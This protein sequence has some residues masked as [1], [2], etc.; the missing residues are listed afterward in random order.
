MGINGEDIKNKLYLRL[1]M[2]GLADTTT[3]KLLNMY[4]DTVSMQI[5][6]E[7]WYHDLLKTEYLDTDSDGKFTIEQN[8]VPYAV[9]AY[10]TEGERHTWQRLTPIDYEYFLNWDSRVYRG[11][12]SMGGGG[13]WSGIRRRYTVLPEGDSDHTV[14][15]ILEI[16]D[17]VPIKIVYY[18]IRPA[19]S[20][21]SIYFEP[22]ITGKVLEAYYT[23]KGDQLKDRSIKMIMDQ[24]EKL[25]KNIRKQAETFEVNALEKTARN[26]KTKDWLNAENDIGYWM[27]Y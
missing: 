25:S 3:D 22:L 16:Q 15:Q 10:G 18:P 1:N 24:N 23:D 14:M 6:A 27:S 21:F 8:I 4:I 7:R 11:V 12:N 26:Q 2:Y 20:D 19:I 13:A 5:A 9:F 17:I